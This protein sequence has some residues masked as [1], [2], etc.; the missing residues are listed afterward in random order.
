MHRVVLIVIGAVA[1]VV[2]GGVL[3]WQA[4]SDPARPGADQIERVAI[5]SVPAP[6]ESQAGDAPAGTAKPAGETLQDS[7]PNVDRETES[8][9]RDM[10]GDQVETLVSR[11]LVDSGRFDVVDPELVD[12]AMGAIASDAS[13]APP[14][15]DAPARPQRPSV[16]QHLAKALFEPSA[17]AAPETAFGLEAALT[18]AERQ[19]EARF[20]LA[21]ARERPQLV[22]SVINDENGA[23]E[24]IRLESDPVFAY[25]LYDLNRRSTVLVSAARLDQPVAVSVPLPR[26]AANAFADENFR[27]DLLKAGRELSNVVQARIARHVGSR[28]VIGAFPAEVTQD[29]PLTIDRGQRD[30]IDA[31]ARMEV[32]REIVEAPAGTRREQFIAL[33][34]VRSVSISAAELQTLEGETVRIGDVV[35]FAADPLDGSAAAQAGAGLAV[36]G[37]GRG[38]G[39]EGVLAE[40]AAAAAGEGLRRERVTV[41]D[42]RVFSDDDRLR[43]PSQFFEQ[44]L[45]GRLAREPRLEI[46]SRESLDELRR[47]Q[48]IG[49]GGRQ[50]YLTQGGGQ[51]FAQAGFVVL[52]DITVRLESQTTAQ[53]VAGAQPRNVRTSYALSATGELRIER[54]DSRTV[55]SFEVA[56]RLPVAA[57]EID[58]IEAGR[59]LAVAFA[60]EASRL[61]LL[62]LFPIE[63]AQKAAN[64]I[65]LTRGADVGLSVGDELTVYRLGA[66]ITDRT[67]GALISSGARTPVGKVRVVDVQPTVATAVPLE[68]AAAIAEGDVAERAAPAPRRAAAASDRAA[69]S[70]AETSQPVREPEGGSV[71]W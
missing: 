33:A 63:V 13:P 59:R 48:S 62:R 21:I 22:W 51:A 31:G 65:V 29:A 53:T 43:A 17:A 6:D 71:P 58:D 36:G 2:V 19:L 12:K 24:A 67:T 3:L 55:S 1:A 39:R 50:S 56:A 11:F 70:R 69:G 45:L 9:I 34:E 20:L 35:R 68:G 5:I 27:A 38:L 16:M 23:P 37:P 46:L 18:D 32:F 30:G 4:M 41:S 60:D 40:Q 42:L 26:G 28:V 66:P 47:E 14:A 52:G 64:T 8:M 44:S 10:L 57:A 25:R 7:A 15:A 54:L 49:G 61:I